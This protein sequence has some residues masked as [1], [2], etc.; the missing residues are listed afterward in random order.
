MLKTGVVGRWATVWNRVTKFCTDIHTDLLYSRLGYNVAMYFRSAFIE[1]RKT[2]RKCRRRRLWF[3]FFGRGVLPGPMGFLLISSCIH[4]ET[5]ILHR[6]L[7]CIKLNETDRLNARPLHASKCA[8]KLHQCKL[9][10]A[11]LWYIRFIL[12]YRPIYTFIYQ[13]NLLSSPLDCR[14][15]S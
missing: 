12:S 5:A 10:N 6:H 7:M 1:V 13:R 8:P 11:L 4:Y 15:L 14:I 2:C 3:D 9:S